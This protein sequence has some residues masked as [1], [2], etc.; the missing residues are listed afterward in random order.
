MVTFGS[1]EIFNRVLYGGHANDAE[2]GRFFT[3]AG[4]TPIFMGG[5]SDY[6]RDTWCYQAKQGILLSGLAMTP[7]FVLASGDSDGY[8]CWFHKSTDVIS[9][10]HHGWMEYRLTRFSPYF[11][12]VNV[13]IAVYPL[14]PDDGFLVHYDIT[15]DQQVIFCAGFGGITPFFGR[16]E[17]TNSKHRNLRD[18]DFD[19]NTARLTE[20][21]AAIDGPGGTTMRIGTDFDAIPELASHAAMLES[22]PSTFLGNHTDGTECVRLTKIIPA[23]GRLCGNLIVLQNSSDEH[24]KELLAERELPRQLRTRIRAKYAALAFHTP[25]PVLDAS[26][27]DTAIALDASFHGKSFYHGA[28]G[29]HAPFL[30]WRGW[31]A[32]VLLG[33]L[34]RVRSAIMSHFDTITPATGPERVWWDGADRPDLDHEGTQYHHLQDSSGHL[35]ALLHRDDIYDMQEVAMD[36]TLYYLE[37][38]ADDATAAAI[39]DRLL[40]L[41]DWEERILDPDHDGLY[42]NFLNTWISDGHSYNGAGC[43]QSSCYNYAANARAAAVGRRLGRDVSALEARAAKIL[44]ALHR[45]L[46]LSNPGVL[47]ESVDTMGSGLVHPSPELST[48][49]LAIDCG[50]LSQMEAWRALKWTERNIKTVRTA[51]RGGML[52]FSSQWLPKKYSTYGIFPAENAALAL[53]FYQVGLADQASAILNGLVDAFAL[54]PYPGSITHVLSAHGGT[55]N[56]DIDFTDVSSCYLRL[57]LEGLWGVRLRGRQATVAPQLPK[58]WPEASLALPAISVHFHRTDYQDELSIHFTGDEVLLRL[59]LRFAEVDQLQVNGVDSEYERVRGIGQPWLEAK[60]PGG[61]ALVRVIYRDE[62]LPTVA[63]AEQTVCPGATAVIQAT[64]DIDEVIGCE[65]KMRV[66]ETNGRQCIVQLEPDATGFLDCLVRAGDTLCPVSFQVLAPLRRQ[67]EVTVSGTQVSI[68]LPYHISLTE[69]HRQEFRSPR[70][71]G[72]SIGQRLN[73][74]YAWEWNQ[75]GHNALEVD[76]SLLRAKPVLVTPGGWRFRTPAN[77]S[78]VVAVSLWDNFPDCVEIPLAGHARALAALHC[79]TTN[80]MQSKVCNAVMEV[81]YQ[82]GGCEKISLVLP[83]NLDDFLH[84]PYQ[85]AFESVPIGRGTHANVA[86]IPL[87]AGRELRAF[88][89]SAVAN[90][91]ILEL[92]ALTCLR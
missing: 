40:E 12:D 52:Y 47:A 70:P 72:Y 54:S 53:A 16:F 63:N 58:E 90:E 78:N 49:Y 67:P 51:G 61:Q 83:D 5:A 59:P 29:Y 35:T 73:G 85:R 55:D 25:D 39:Y 89:M 31:Y 48:T 66:V 65:G 87:D 84:A 26:V 80:A 81:V 15:T 37:A 27:P 75:Y 64:A 68:D 74:R 18:A 32:P 28:I 3:F 20:G 10:W 62:A 42:Q 57:V 6:T 24:L 91:V 38:S 79:A 14:N 46:W 7:G 17:A 86:V 36:M 1:S 60:L 41:L 13:Q 9:S 71:Q 34:D 43:A 76:D 4:D 8:S 21:G 50:A 30:G 88:R 77:G 92:L 33:W 23:G 22:F 2:Q 69:I 45:K 82:D 19:G 56:G 44:A 11:P